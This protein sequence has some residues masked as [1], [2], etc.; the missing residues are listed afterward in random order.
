MLAF[1]EAIKA[2]IGGQKVQGTI[3]REECLISW[4]SEL[5][6]RGGGGGRLTVDFEVMSLDEPVPFEVTGAQDKG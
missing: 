5:R 4:T 2:L 3:E 6:G 1:I